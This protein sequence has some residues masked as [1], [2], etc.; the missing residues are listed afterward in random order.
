MVKALRKSL[1]LSQAQFAAL[2]VTEKILAHLEK[3]HVASNLPYVGTALR[4]HAF[5]ASSP[6]S[7]VVSAACMGL[8]PTFSW[9]SSPSIANIVTPW[10]CAQHAAA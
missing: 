9:I 10:T 7:S 5:E 1:K 3:T 4:T 6:S 8:L 2:A